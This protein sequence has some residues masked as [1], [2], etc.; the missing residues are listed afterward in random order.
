MDRPLGC[1]D[2]DGA[3]AAGSALRL[4][5]RDGEVLGS[6][7]PAL[8][9]V[10]AARLSL[11]ADGSLDA[12]VAR[13]VGG[14]LDHLAANIPALR[15]T[16][17]AEAVHQLRVASRR[18]RA[19]LGE[20][21]RASPSNPELTAAAARAKA[22]A[23]ALGAARDWHVL[24]EGLERGP[25]KFLREEPDFF[26]LLDAVELRRLRAVE[27]ARAAI[28]APATQQFMRE[29]RGLISRGT[30][31]EGAGWSAEKGSARD[32]AVKSLNR[33]QKHAAKRCENV[34]DL[35]P[36][37]RHQA[38]IA[39]KKVRYVAECFESLFS[40]KAARRYLNELANIQDQ[41]GEENDR[42][43]AARLL[44]EI[45]AEDA[46]RETLRAVW[47]LR[48]WRAR[49]QEQGYL[50]TKASEKRLRRLKPFWR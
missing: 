38:R 47:F 1:P 23:D 8:V 34:A 22:I 32:F 40:R 12:A 20:L 21:K 49:A 36:E 29:L 27:A 4:V 18:L 6:S 42:E 45:A 19:V 39:L 50:A 16:G 48:G 10:K 13:I 30:W 9:S 5:A 14:C 33:L 24:R 43:T 41:L 44:G 46:S 2:P 28:A 25:R 3:A 37:H 15:E 7:R 17:D 26:T 35:K 11:S 31:R